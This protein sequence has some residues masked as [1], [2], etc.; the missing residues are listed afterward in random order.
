MLADCAFV[1]MSLVQSQASDRLCFRADVVGS[2]AGNVCRKKFIY[3]FG[4]EGVPVSRNS[5]QNLSFLE[6]RG[7]RYLGIQPRICKCVGKV[8]TLTSDAMLAF[9]K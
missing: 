9:S 2:G 4:M 1:P 7:Y 5:A 3:I 8:I 6:W